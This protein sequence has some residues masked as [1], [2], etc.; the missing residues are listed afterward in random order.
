MVVGAGIVA[1]FVISC[2]TAIILV[3]SNLLAAKYLFGGGPHYDRLLALTAL[4]C[5][6]GA[7]GAL[8]TL[9]L[10]GGRWR[11]LVAAMISTIVSFVL[12]SR[13]IGELEIAATSS[14]EAERSMAFMLL[15]ASVFSNLVAVVHRVDVSRLRIGIIVILIVFLLSVSIAGAVAAPE[16]AV[17]VSFL[18][19]FAFWILLPA[20][21]GLL[22]PPSSV[23]HLSSED[24]NSVTP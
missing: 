2:I 8:L 5:S 19:I 7:G 22:I 12:V 9:A 18:I 17:G 14:G 13:W 15:L 23:T 6:V 10:D 24:Q 3:L 16:A 21:T 4:P 20:L 11:A 1:L